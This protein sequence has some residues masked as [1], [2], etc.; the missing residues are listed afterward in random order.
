M[1]SSALLAAAIGGTVA[2]VAAVGVTLGAIATVAFAAATVGLGGAAAFALA[3]LFTCTFTPC[4]ALTHGACAGALLTI[5]NKLAG[6]AAHPFTLSNRLSV[7]AVIGNDATSFG[8]ADVEPVFKL[9]LLPFI[10]ISAPLAYE[11]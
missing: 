9:I 4:P 3:L 5:D 11:P 8:V 7:C 1:L 2:T 10:N 6:A